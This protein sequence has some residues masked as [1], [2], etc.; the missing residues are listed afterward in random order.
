MVRCDEALD[1]EDLVCS[2]GAE[3]VCDPKSFGIAVKDHVSPGESAESELCIF[4]GRFPVYV[5]SEEE[6]VAGQ[7]RNVDAAQKPHRIGRIFF[8]YERC[9]V[10]DV[11][12]S[13]VV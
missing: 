8:L 5:C 11:R 4:F 2:E 6:A 12:G 3:Y 7:F 10:Y 13:F 1:C 9:N